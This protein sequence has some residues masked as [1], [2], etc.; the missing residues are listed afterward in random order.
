MPLLCKLHNTIIINNFQAS[1]AQ[2]LGIVINLP[3]FCHKYVTD[4]MFFELTNNSNNYNFIK[5]NYLI[6]FKNTELV[7]GILKD[8]FNV[9]Y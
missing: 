1:I 6:N 3:D 2:V 4:W 7:R 9:S 8:I 5:N